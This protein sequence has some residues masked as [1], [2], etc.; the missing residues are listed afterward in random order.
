MRSQ[1]KPLKIDEAGLH[2]DK[3]TAISRFEIFLYDVVFAKVDTITLELQDTLAKPNQ[4]SLQGTFSLD[5]MKVKLEVNL[6]EMNKVLFTAVNTP[7]GIQVDLIGEFVTVL[8]HGQLYQRPI[9]RKPRN[10]HESLVAV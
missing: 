5:L 1:D 2:L 8:H 9:E 3:I 6:A 7:S 4:V 10:Y